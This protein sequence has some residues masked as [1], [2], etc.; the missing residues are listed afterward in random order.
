MAEIVERESTASNFI[1]AIALIVI[2]GIIMGALYYG[3]VF[4][5]INKDKKVDVDVNITAPAA[6]AR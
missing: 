6:P 1:W 5:N 3:G 2:V 4:R